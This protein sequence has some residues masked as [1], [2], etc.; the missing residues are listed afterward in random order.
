VDDRT[1]LYVQDDSPAAE[2]RFYARFE[3]D[4]NGFDP[5]EASNR[6]RTRIFVAF[7]GSPLRRLA[8]VVLRRQHG[9]YAVMGR[10]RL[11]SGFQVST[12]FVPIAD[13]PHAIEIDWRRATGLGGLD[14]SCRFSVD[15]VPLTPL[16]A[17]DNGTRPLELVR[18]GALSVKP[19]ASGVPYW[20]EYEWHRSP[21]PGP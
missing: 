3:F 21:P 5:G 10:C 8:A 20:D 14:G 1:S 17:L 2:D 6:F 19:G 16:L 11:D 4:P 15:G 9:A 13:A 7:G 12:G 18:L